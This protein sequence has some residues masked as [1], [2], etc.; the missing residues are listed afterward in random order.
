MNFG[1]ANFHADFTASKGIQ[2]YSY[3]EMPAGRIITVNGD[4]LTNS[5]ILAI[6]NGIIMGDGNFTNDYGGS[7]TGRGQV[8]TFLDNRGSI[9]LTGQLQVQSAAYNCGNIHIGLGQQLYVADGIGNDGLIALDGGQL[10]TGNSIDNQESGSIVGSGGIAGQL[11]N[12]GGLIYANGATP[13]VVDNF[14]GNDGELRMADGSQL[15]LF[16]EELFN[17]GRIVLEGPRAILAG[18]NLDNYGT[19]AGAGR[20]TNYIAPTGASVVRAEGGVLTMAS[21]GYAEAG[22]S[23]G[24]WEVA[25]GATMVFSHGIHGSGADVVLQGGTFENTGMGMSNGGRI[26]GHGTFRGGIWNTSLIS[27]GEGDLDLMGFL[28]NN[29]AAVVQ[30]QPGCKLTIYGSLSGEGTFTGDGET[31]V[32]GQVSPGHSPGQISFEG[33]L[34]LGGGASMLMQLG[35][36]ERGDGYDA[37]LVGGKLSLSGPLEVELYDGFQPQLGDSFDLF[38]W[39]TLSGE[40]SSITLPDLGGGLYWDASKFYVTGS[41]TAVPE[42]GGIMLLICGALA[43]VLWRRRKNPLPLRAAVA[44]AAVALLAAPLSAETITFGSGS[45]QPLDAG[46]PSYTESGYTFTMIQYGNYVALNPR[47]GPGTDRYLDLMS[48][49]SDAV[50]RVTA[51][52]GKFDLSSVDVL[53]YGEVSRGPATFTGSGGQTYNFTTAY[54]TVTFDSSVWKDLEYLDIKKAN[55]HGYAGS[56]GL[57]NFHLSTVPEPGSLALLICGALAV[58]CFRRRRAILGRV[59]AK[60][61]L[62]AALA[63]G[64]LGG[65]AGPAN[66][67]DYHWIGPPGYFYYFDKPTAWDPNAVPG[68]DDVAWFDAQADSTI[69]YF[70][71]SPTNSELNVKTDGYVGFGPLGEPMQYTL[72]GSANVIHSGLLLADMRLDV[73]NVLSVNEGGLLQVYN[74]SYNPGSQVSTNWL[75]IG[76]GSLGGVL[77]EDGASLTAGPV[78]HDVGYGPAGMGYLTFRT[79]ATGDSPSR[80]PPKARPI[81][82]R[83]AAALARECST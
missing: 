2:N 7:L 57:D 18:D 16:G 35:G 71:T 13:L 36:T 80:W 42:P 68:L 28:D 41:L 75:D 54:Q 23:D 64:L 4:G 12:M 51:A 11:F 34:T 47:N 6:D 53:G 15:T 45:T 39:G 82:C 67:G 43:L 14:A 32:L 40:F 63:A 1:T 74:L 24:R 30:I 5:G 22:I 81:A 55:P 61:L 10:G 58:F 65:P 72:T 27:V 8:M 76:D 59:A 9:D 62:A 48:Y 31:V 77:V 20:I 17:N 52:T 56:I 66:A 38:D 3:M 79:G 69:V 19:I 25:H 29:S 73:G 50:V 70:G 49:T 83:S 60:C 44:L 21:G 37:I 46:N 26:M 33:A 78:V